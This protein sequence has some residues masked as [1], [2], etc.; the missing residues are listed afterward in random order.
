[1]AVY[2]FDCRACETRFEL[3]APMAQGVTEPRCTAC[4]STRVVR[5]YSVSTPNL[6]GAGPEPGSLRTAD[7]RALTANVAGS[8]A[9][10][11]G[12]RAIRE[13]AE[14]ARRGADPDRL[15]EFVR[16]VKEERASK[17]RTPE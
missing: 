13:V 2:E 7:P 15:H 14:Q 12:D 11:T 3:Q 6:R 4:G 9:Q 16:E 8:Y 10:Q 5:R 17:D 1:M